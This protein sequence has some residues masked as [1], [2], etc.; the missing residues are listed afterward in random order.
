MRITQPLCK[1]LRDVLAVLGYAFIIRISKMPVKASNHHV[2]VNNFREKSSAGIDGLKLGAGFEQDCCAGELA[3][4]QTC[5]SM[6]VR[7][8]APIVMTA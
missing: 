5:G 8:D 3:A 4:G 6:L 7:E 1:R 2:R